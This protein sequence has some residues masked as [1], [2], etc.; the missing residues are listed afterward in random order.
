MSGRSV[1]Q[2][3][4]LMDRLAAAAAAIDPVPDVAV[5]AAVASFRWRSIDTELA[6]L[7]FDSERS[8]D[9]LVGVRSEG[10]ARQLTFESPHLLVELE[11][12]SHAQY[13]LVGQLVPPTAADVE[14]RSP[15]DSVV[16]SAD[17]LGRFRC[18]RIEGRAISL[19]IT[20][21]AGV[22]EPADTAWV[23]IAP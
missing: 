21:L 14:I 5:E 16:V 2:V 13:P 3:E 8:N 20:P 10:G 9:Q 15:N 4:D 22:A 17:E 7:L 6:F 1:N 18:D 19:R 12:D 23:A 11:L